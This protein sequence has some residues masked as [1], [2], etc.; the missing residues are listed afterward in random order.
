M[1][2]AGLGQMLRSGC[3]EQRKVEAEGSR[4]M[5][6]YYVKVVYRAAVWVRCQINH[7]LE[8]LNG[9]RSLYFLN[10][11]SSRISGP[12]QLNIQWS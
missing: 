9:E 11:I 3:T 4:W 6:S 5:L 7:I 10:L 1:V 12:S 8:K 2:L